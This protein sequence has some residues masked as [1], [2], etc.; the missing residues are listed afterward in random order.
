MPST[1]TTE[2]QA[3]LFVFVTCIA[4]V[5]KLLLIDT[6]YR[7]SM[8]SI[9]CHFVHVQSFQD[10]KACSSEAPSRPNEKMECS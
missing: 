10:M 5:Q 9:L 6:Q 7:T 2:S 4:R 8:E 1:G 3:F